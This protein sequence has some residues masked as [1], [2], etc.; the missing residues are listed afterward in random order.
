MGLTPNGY[1]LNYVCETLSYQY[2]SHGCDGYHGIQVPGYGFT[3][4]FTISFTI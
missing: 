2:L 4:C 1:E 3:T